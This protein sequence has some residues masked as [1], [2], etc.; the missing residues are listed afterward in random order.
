MHDHETAG[1]DL[2]LLLRR[3]IREETGLVPVAMASK[4]E[5]GDLVLRPGRD[6]LQDKTI[7]IETFFSKIVM[8]RNRLRTLL[9][10]R[11]FIQG[12]FRLASGATSNVYFDCKRATLDPH[13]GQRQR[14]LHVLGLRR[15]V[16]RA[17]AALTATLQGGGLAVEADPLAHL[18]LPSRPGT[19]A[20]GAYTPASARDCICDHLS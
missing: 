5:G 9:L 18:Y 4:W 14:V 3:I 16:E 15:I 8:L 6:G 17:T 19:G 7:P 10:E 2:E 13:R 20:W 1:P 12:T 11:C